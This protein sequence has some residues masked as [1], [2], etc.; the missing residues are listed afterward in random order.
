MELELQEDGS[1][2][3]VVQRRE[4]A[5]IALLLAPPI[6][7]LECCNV[8]GSA[9]RLHYLFSSLSPIQISF[10]SRGKNYE[11]TTLI[12][13]ITL[14]RGFPSSDEAGGVDISSDHFRG[15][16]FG[17]RFYRYVGAVMNSNPAICYKW[18]VI[19]PQ[20][21]K[22]H[23]ASAPS[24]FFLLFVEMLPSIPNLLTVSDKGRN[25]L[26][27]IISIDVNLNCIEPEYF[28]SSFPTCSGHL[29]K[30]SS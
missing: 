16:I 20:T 19:R 25:P 10:P 8:A 29:S 21:S 2:R 11:S 6:W 3:I 12:I 7:I 22:P 27:F 17:R 4:T 28:L 1:C 30:F 14:K 9:A 23:K 5:G 13:Y 26:C 24:I 18:S 15:Q